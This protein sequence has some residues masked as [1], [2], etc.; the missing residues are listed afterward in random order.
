MHSSNRSLEKLIAGEKI[1]PR[2]TRH[3]TGSDARL[4]IPP[5]HLEVHRRIARHRHTPTPLVSADYSA[6][7]PP[8]ITHPLIRRQRH[9]QHLRNRRKI[10]PVI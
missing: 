4:R 3:R 8:P 7:P 9:L 1:R 2:A 6:R 10:Q 5:R